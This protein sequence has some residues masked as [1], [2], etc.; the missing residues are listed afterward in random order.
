MSCNGCTELY[1]SLFRRSS[2]QSTH[3]TFGLRFVR[4]KGQIDPSIQVFKNSRRK[5]EPSEPFFR[6]IINLIKTE[7]SHVELMK[8]RLLAK[9]VLELIQL[10]HELF[11]K[12]IVMC[13]K[14]LFVN[15]IKEFSDKNKLLF[16]LNKYSSSGFNFL[17]FP[18]PS[19]HTKLF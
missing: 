11:L 18:L 16:S 5:S 9:Y 3:E 12:R 19:K 10:I 6:R 4:G 15:I 13:S 2:L 1:K 14:L 7:Y 8:F 17:K